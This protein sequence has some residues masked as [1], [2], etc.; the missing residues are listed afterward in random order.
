MTRAR[1]GLT[2]AA[3]AVLLTSQVAHA[4]PVLDTMGPLG[5]NAGVQGVVSGPGA[6]SAYENPA[7]L[8]DADADVLLA[9]AVISEQVRVTLDGRKGGDVPLPVGGRDILGPGLAPIPNDVVPTPWLQNGCSAGTEAGS[10]PGNGFAA[11]PRQSRG[12][13]GKGR[14][15]LTLGLVQHLVPDRLTVGLYG[16]LPLG[17]YTTA[18]SFY[19]D[20]R[21]ALFSNSLHPELYGDRLTAVS[22]AAGAAFKLTPDL[23]V[24]AGL[25]ISLAN[26]AAS[27]TYVRDTSDYDK[28]LL[29]T[30]VTTQVDVAP[31]VGVRYRPAR[32]LRIGGVLQSPESFTIDTTVNATL[33][34]GTESGTTRRDVYHWMPWR[35]GVGVEADVVRR[36]PYTMSLTGSVKYALWSAY[37]DRHGQ[38]PGDY[39]ADL[40]WKD[41]LSGALG[42]R[43]VWGRARAFVDASYRASPVPDQVGRSSYVDNDRVGMAVGADVAFQVGSKRIRP[44]FQVFGS[45]LV[46]R[47]VDKDDARMKDELPD[48][49]IFGAT[50]DPVPGSTGLQTNSPG[51]PGFASD[52]YIVGGALTLDVPL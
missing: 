22:I 32:Y 36:G 21:E 26:T 31:S 1:R 29:N 19:P 6:A 4:S 49:A 5:G 24:G 10:C 13:S 41:T 47:H 11:R 20:E 39:G 27:S 43:H 48:G 52:G 18:R 51:W 17:S 42:V 35:V 46:R 12:T 34:S 45:R 3:I 28:L 15:Y 33:P 14:T 40:A 25:S 16:M 9:F 44:G 38:S 30:A 37:R 8:V 23:S 7:M 2:A 50:H